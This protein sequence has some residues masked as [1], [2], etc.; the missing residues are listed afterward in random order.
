MQVTATDLI[1]RLAQHK[2]LGSAPREEL[3]W[4]VEHGSL[5]T[6]GVGE[7]LSQKGHP[8][9]GLY[10]ILS[11]RLAL[12]VDRGAGPSKLVEWGAGDV[13]GMLPYSRLVSPPGDS[14][15]QE[16][17]EILA[18]HR[19]HL[20]EMIQ[21]CFEITSILVHRMID[22]A[23]LFTSS[24]LDN[25]KLISL[26]KLSAGLAHELNNPASAIE[27][28]VCLLTDR[29]EES[30][31]ATR[32]LEAAGLSET[33]LAAVDAIRE[34]CL[35]KKTVKTRSALEQADRE[36]AIYGWLADRGLD[37]S[38]AQILADTEVT[39]EALNSIVEIVPGPTANAV[40]RWAA[41]GCAVRSLASEIQSCSSRISGLVMA[42]KGFT[43]MDQAM[44]AERVDLGLGLSDTVTVLNSKAREKSVA[45][46]IDLQAGLP[47]VFG[48]A[49][50]LNQI[51]GNLID[52]ALDAAPEGGRVEVSA[53]CEGQ[54][55]VVRIIDNG[56]GIPSEIRSRVFDPFFTT[57]PMGQ[58]TGLGLDIARRLVGHNDGLIEFDSQP[59]RTEFRV[60]LPVAGD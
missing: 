49:A 60:S 58:G 18:L 17:L 55:I 10:V 59:G 50:E 40:L 45:V 42:V 36:D 37:T 30:E 7:M 20:R 19:D 15:A 22:R 47:R 32:A 54:H 39:F 38:N 34:S 48:F 31:N 13:T 44:V 41:A 35:A 12:F 8:V 53:C 26:G 51:W 1:E 9:E 11:G 6:L 23:R 28:S 5:R 52:N 4:L 16:P 14:I 56:P 29:L 24:E 46:A 25:E 2:T 21:E 27:R 33:Q 57:K 43:H 3:A